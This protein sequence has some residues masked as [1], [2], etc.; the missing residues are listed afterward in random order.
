MYFVSACLKT[1]LARRDPRAVLG[2]F[3]C[4]VVDLDVVDALVEVDVGVLA[5]LVAVGVDVGVVLTAVL[6][7][8]ALEELPEEPPQAASPK[9]ASIRIDRMPAAGLQRAMLMLDMKLLF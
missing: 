3:G 5:V 7:A 2:L 9:Q 6:V 4:G 8:V 1:E